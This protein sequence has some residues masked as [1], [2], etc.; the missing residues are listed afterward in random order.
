MSPFEQ[1]AS[2]LHEVFGGDFPDDPLKIHQAMARAVL[3]Y[4]AVLALIRIGKSRSIGRISP[5]DVLLGF[6]LGSLASRGI[7][8]HSSLSGT[9]ASSAALVAAH[10]LLTLIACR[11]HWVGNLIKGRS[12]LIV[13][14]GKTIPESMLQHHIS[15]HDLEEAMRIKGYDD[16]SQVREAYK[17]RNGEI[18]VVTK[19]E[20]PRVI[21]VAVQAGVQTV[22]IQLE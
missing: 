5:I 14:Q 12:H 16:V 9:V 7:T 1:L 3:I 20:P 18:S 6:I 21:E 19:R 8:G 10:W 22:R 13:E 17:E 15:I 4:L 2:T 11:S